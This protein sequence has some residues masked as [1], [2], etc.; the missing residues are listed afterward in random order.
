[1]VDHQRENAPV[2]WAPDST[3]TTRSENEHVRPAAASVTSLPEGK[4]DLCEGSGVIRWMQPGEDGVLREQEHPC[5]RGCGGW[6][7]HP[8]AERS[9]V[10]GVLD[11]TELGDR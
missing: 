8:D 11:P 7:K 3:Q 9:R 6:W 5:I 4:C 1:M 10:A 2:V